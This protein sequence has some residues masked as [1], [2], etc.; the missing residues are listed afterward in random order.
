MAL[1]ELDLS[2]GACVPLSWAAAPVN[3]S[4]VFLLS[5]W[6]VFA[7]PEQERQQLSLSPLGYLPSWW[8]VNECAIRDCF[9][10][11]L[12]RISSLDPYLLFRPYLNMVGYG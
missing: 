1:L 12:R 3:G 6:R 4:W 11:A 2:P 7:V 10:G 8:I 5:L 9:L